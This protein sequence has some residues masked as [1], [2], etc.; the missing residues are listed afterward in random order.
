[1]MK[2]AAI[3]IIRPLVASTRPWPLTRLLR[4]ARPIC[5]YTCQPYASFEVRTT[6]ARFMQ[7]SSELI[8]KR[9]DE[10]SAS[11]AAPISISMSRAASRRPS[12]LVP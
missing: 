12:F 7:V 8:T 11:P 2:I 4:I 6:R 10:W 1:M 9:L 3:T 5:G